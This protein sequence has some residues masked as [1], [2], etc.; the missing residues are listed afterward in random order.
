MNKII[1]S[2][3]ESSLDI[4]NKEYPNKEVKYDEYGKPYV[5]CDE[6]FNIS[7]SWGITAFISSDKK[8]GI[9]IEY[10]HYK[11]NILKKM[12]TQEEI[13][14]INNSQDK[15][16][17]FTK[18]W[19]MKESFAKMIGVGLSFGFKN[20]DTIKLRD[21]FNTFIIDDY[22]ISYIEEDYE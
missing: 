17:E 21:K 20:I 3:E 5:E 10:I 15:A 19:T 1:I 8:V 4:L 2:K 14:L 9:D 7:D 16:L 6:Q 18:M 22:V 12:F 13:D 11:E